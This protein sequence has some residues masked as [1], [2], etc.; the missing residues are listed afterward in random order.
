MDHDDKVIVLS[1]SADKTCSVTKVPPTGEGKILNQYGVFILCVLFYRII[2][3]LHVL[4]F[5]CN[6]SCA[7]SI[8]LMVNL[9]VIFF[10]IELQ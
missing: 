6:H 1:V 7:H 5:A 8:V 2:V 10:V 9:I 3:V 4:V